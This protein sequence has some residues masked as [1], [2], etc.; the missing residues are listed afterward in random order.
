MTC[1]KDWFV[2]YRDK[3][4]GAK[5]YLGD[6]R[7]HE[8]KSHSDVCVTLPSSHVKQIKTRMYVP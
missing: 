4:N 6:D 8:I 7:S 3:T 2:N 5:I 1:H